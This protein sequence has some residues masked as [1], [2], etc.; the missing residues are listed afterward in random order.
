ME[1]GEASTPAS[2]LGPATA[3]TELPNPHQPEWIFSFYVLSIV[4]RITHYAVLALVAW[5][6]ARVLEFPWL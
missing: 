2:N 1:A 4:L 6:R 3:V 5:E